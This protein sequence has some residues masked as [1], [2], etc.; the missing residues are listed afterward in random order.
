M[1]EDDDFLLALRLQEQFDNETSAPAWTDDDYPSSK[2][3]KID[4]HDLMDVISHSRSRPE[5]PMS[6]VDGSWEML[7]PNPDVRAM[8]LQFNDMFFWGKLSG[9][10]VKWS[11]RMTLCA[12]VCSYEGRGGL[13]SI[14]L[15]EPLLK[16]RPRKDLV[17]TLL[18][19][20]IHALLF[21][22][23]NN[24][25]RDGHGPEFCKHM[26]RINQASG[27][28]I[29]I[30]HSF[31]NEVDVYRQ[32]WWRCNGPC[33]N[34]RPFFGY[35]KRAM[36]RPPSTRDPWWA[37]HQ[38]TCGGTYTKIKEPENYGKTGKSKRDGNKEKNPTT[39]N[40]KKTKPPS[41]TTGSGS[42][43]IRNIIPFS[44]R[45]FLLRGNSQ[46]ST[47]KQ[48]SQNPLSPSRAQPNHLVSPP[49]NDSDSPRPWPTETSLDKRV[50]SGA[51]NILHKK[52]ISNTNA[53]ININGSPVRISK[54]NGNLRAKQMTVQD[55]FQAKVRKS[56]EKVTSTAG[57]SKPI[58]NASIENTALYNS[59]TASGTNYLISLSKTGMINNC[60]SSS[61][62]GSKPGSTKP[63]LSKYFGSAENDTRKFPDSNLKSFGNCRISETSTPG[64]ISKHLSS[65][66][67]QVSN[68]TTSGFSNTG[69]PQKPSTIASE[70]SSIHFGSSKKTVI[71]FPSHKNIDSPWT[72]GTLAS[73][74]RKRSWEEHNSE[75]FFNNF[76]QTIN[77]ITTT[78]V[79]K[80]EE[81]GNAGLSAVG[82]QEAN[83]QPVQIT[84]HCPVCCIKVLESKINEHLDSCLM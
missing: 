84:I 6:V 58:T 1:M 16:L 12:G 3:R 18:H 40:S 70:S 31:H 75:H 24:R 14:R 38:R 37:E 10:E 21:V 79:K 52:S 27:T 77:E 66:Q 64:H 39:D 36:N 5:K 17:E 8:F 62:I 26:N 30:Y 25:D 45:G 68:I 42:Q 35:V 33:Q 69:S 32:H 15:S 34:R 59:P 61:V 82:D 7:D 44:G 20:M 43:D 78:T 11:A 73:G 63:H 51:S 83:S 81:I 13:C 48:P 76:Q 49:S 28:N 23:Q 50:S 53:F 67:R 22:T 4:S 46:I 74:A 57:S 55:L 19:E 72:S 71:N 2:K 60:H 80:Q 65:N 41:S 29:T 54:V 47:D 9:V 56:P